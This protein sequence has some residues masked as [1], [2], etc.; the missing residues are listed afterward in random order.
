MNSAAQPV[1]LAQRP[2]P[3]HRSQRRH[4]QAAGTFGGH[5]WGLSHGHAQGHLNGMKT[6]WEAGTGR[7]R[8]RSANGGGS[9]VQGSQTVQLTFRNRDE[10]TSGLLR[11]HEMHPDG[12]PLCNRP[13][14]DWMVFT[15]LGSGEVDCG[16]CALCGEAK[17]T[18]RM[19]RR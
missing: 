6:S 9:H 3:S 14:P 11:V 16:L 13:L 18:S 1:D 8:L 15:P 10:A 5:E 19:R 12:A 7:S 2:H 4:T 17:G